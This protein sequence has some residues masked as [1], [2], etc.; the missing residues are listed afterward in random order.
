VRRWIWPLLGA[1][2]IVLVVVALLAVVQRSLI[3]HPLRLDAAACA[4]LA[5]IHGFEAWTNADGQAIGYRS[6]PGP[7]G[8]RWPCSSRTAT[9]A[10]PCSAR[11]TPPRYEPPPRTV[12]SR[13][14][15]WPAVTRTESPNPFPGRPASEMQV[16]VNKIAARA[17][18]ASTKLENRAVPAGHV[19]SR[20]VKTLLEERRARKR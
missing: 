6:L 10:A 3:Y 18:M 17:V 4:D 12:Q 20:G 7:D 9:P 8:R 2:G 11:S 16:L 5:D 19:R 1:G 15:C 13:F 14:T